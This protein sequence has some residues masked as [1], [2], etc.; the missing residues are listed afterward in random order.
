MERFRRFSADMIV[1]WSKQL[2]PTPFEGITADNQVVMARQVI[3]ATSTTSARFVGRN[4]D[5]LAT[6]TQETEFKPYM[7]HELRGL[8]AHMIDAIVSPIDGDRY[9]S[10]FD[11]MFANQ[12]DMFDAYW[13]SRPEEIDLDV[14]DRRAKVVKAFSIGME[15]ELK[16]RHEAVFAGL[17]GGLG[18]KE[19]PTDF[20]RQVYNRYID[21]F[22]LYRNYLLR[23]GTAP[24]GDHEGVILNGL[25]GE[26][27]ACEWFYKTLP[28][29]YALQGV[30]VAQNQQPQEY[31]VAF[32]NSYPT[33]SAFAKSHLDTIRGIT[34][35]LFPQGGNDSDLLANFEIVG[36]KGKRK[37]VLKHPVESVKKHFITISRQPEFHGNTPLIECPA[38]AVIGKGNALK[39]IFDIYGKAAEMLYGYQY[40]VVKPRRTREQALFI[41][42]ALIPAF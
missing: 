18:E 34:Y 38:M 13:V 41:R 5:K 39:K 28:R 20:T 11:Y 14:L 36:E 23:Y 2:K 8:M 1:R 6:I 35:Y 37:L 29:M 7:R 40:S 16:G 31:A 22:T 12:L 26:I 19:E 42:P 27:K 30:E 4:I 24:N 15:W 33:I 3:P 10:E 17:R 9:V 25:R 32:R 21:L